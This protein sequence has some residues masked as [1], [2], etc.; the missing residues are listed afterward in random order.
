MSPADINEPEMAETTNSR[1]GTRKAN[2]EDQQSGY[3]SEIK[4]Y[5]ITEQRQKYPYCENCVRGNMVD[6]YERLAAFLCFVCELYLCATCKSYHWKHECMEVGGKQSE[7]LEEK[8]DNKGMEMKLLDQLMDESKEK[9]EDEFQ[10][11]KAS[12]C[13]RVKVKHELDKENCRITGL[14]GLDSKKWVACDE[15]NSCVKIFEFGSNLLLRYIQFKS[16]PSG[17]AEIHA[18]MDKQCFLAVTLP[19]K[20]QI[21]LLDVGKKPAIEQNPIHTEKPCYDIEF[22][23]DKIFTLCTEGSFSHWYVYVI[24]TK[25]DKSENFYIDTHKVDVRGLAVFS[26]GIFLTDHHNHKV[27]RRNSEGQTT[28]EILIPR[29]MSYGISVDPDNMVYICARGR[30]QI[31]KLECDLKEYNEMLNKQTNYLKDPCALSYYRSMSFIGHLSLSPSDNF[32]T[33]VRL[34]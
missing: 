23:N 30:D 5:D 25:G 10:K 17:V 16:K 1:L 13:S 20:R 14:C 27:Y 33:V 12:I 11:K 29:S 7:G 28:S 34:L 6:L 8:N 3:F 24:S 32:V 9:R 21:M 26:G 4:E 31:Y 2:Q 18:Q 22:Y 19:Q 15:S